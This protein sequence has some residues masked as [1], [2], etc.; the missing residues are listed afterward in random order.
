MRK[1]SHVDDYNNV[2]SQSEYFAE[3]VQSHY[4]DFDDYDTGDLRELCKRASHIKRV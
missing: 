1:N 2:E 3:F 4:D